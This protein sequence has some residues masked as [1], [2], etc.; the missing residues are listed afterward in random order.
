MPTENVL[1]IKS[2]TETIK[3]EI[4][5]K[6][7]QKIKETT[8]SKVDISNLTQ[9]FYFVK[10]TAINGSFGVKKIIKK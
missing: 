4:Y 9:G 8:E 10:V 6:L 1:I 5:N 3:I 2:K 7:G